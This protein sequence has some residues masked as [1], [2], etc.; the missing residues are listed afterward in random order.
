[1][2]AR[3]TEW[4]S[5]KW[6]LMLDVCA[7][8]GRAATIRR[9][10]ASA[11]SASSMRKRMG[12]ASQL[13]QFVEASPCL[14][15]GVQHHER[16]K[17]RF[18]REHAVV[19]PGC[20]GHGVNAAYTEQNPE[21]GSQGQFSHRGCACLRLVRN[22]RIGR[23]AES[24]CDRGSTLGHMPSIRAVPRGRKRLVGP[25]RGSGWWEGT[26]GLSRAAAQRD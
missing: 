12:V 2:S 5:S 10:S 20:G 21:G 4:R 24:S 14:P 18:Y 7:E 15:D 23:A 1:M 17:G 16:P 11:S 22:V 26:G 8:P 3:S 19:S 25:D 6:S 13:T 9:P